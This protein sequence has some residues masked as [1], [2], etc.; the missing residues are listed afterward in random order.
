MIHCDEVFDI[1][2]RGPFPTG[3]ASD[4]IVEGHLGHCDD[5]RRL[6][7]ALRPAIE[8][9]QEAITPDEGRDLPRYWGTVGE[10]QR[11]GSDES[12]A[13]QT[14]RK[15]AFG[16]RP[17][18]ATL[19]AT[20]AAAW[21]G[22]ARLAAAVLLGL[23]LAGL[24]RQATR[25][26]ED[27]LGQLAGRVKSAHWRLSESGDR[28]F[29]EQGFSAACR[30]PVSGLTLVAAIT[31]PVTAPVT[32]A[33]EPPAA[34]GSAGGLDAADSHGSAADGTP[35]LACCLGCHS[36]KDHKLLAPTAVGRLV[37]ACGACHE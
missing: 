4:G 19:V 1:L 21:S 33:A 17:A 15:R 13:T 23:V 25:S 16:H 2:T 34:R 29:A 36:A 12:V 9:L 35:R 10:P 5:C 37:Q 8:L 6:A 27:A 24:L 14:R 7:E 30:R 22:A 3:A 18:A 32:E 20:R 28:W 26:H 31:A 11:F